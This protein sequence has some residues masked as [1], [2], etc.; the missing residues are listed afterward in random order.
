LGNM[1]DVL[2][3]RESVTNQEFGASRYLEEK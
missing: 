1:M 2:S 3:P